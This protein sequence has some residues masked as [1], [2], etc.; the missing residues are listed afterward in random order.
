MAT[1]QRPDVYVEEK[2]Q[3][4]GPIQAAA[5]GK[6]GMQAITEKGP[7]G[8]IVRSSS[9][10]DWVR[11]FGGR[12]TRGDG[13]YEAKM[14]FDEGGVELLTSRIV[15]FSDLDDATSYTGG[16]AYRTH[17]TE[18]VAATSAQKI[19]SAFPLELVAGG[20]FDLD[21]DNAGAATVTF[22][23][24]AGYVDDTTSYPVADQVGLTLLLT[25]DGG[26]QQTVTFGTAT[27]LAQVVED[28]NQ[29]IYGGKAEDNGGQLRITSDTKGTDSTVVINGGTHGLTF[30][31]PVAGTGDVGDIRAVTAAEFKTVVEADTTALC[32]VQG[33]GAVLIS[34]PTTGLTSELDFQAGSPS[35][36]TALGLSVEVIVGT[37]LGATYSTLKL[38]AGYHGYVSPGLKGNSL[39]SKITQNPL[40][41]SAGAGSDL[42]ADAAALA[43]T[44]QMVT[45]SGI[46]AGTVLKIW[47]GTNTEYKEVEKVRVV[48]TAGTPAFYADLTTG[49]TNSFTAA[50]TLIESCEFDLEVYDGIELVET[51]TALSML[52]TADNYVETVLNDDAVGSEYVVATDLDAACGVGAD[53][54]ATDTAAVV[55][56]SGTDETTGLVDADW[57]GSE[58]G[59]TGLYAFDTVREF[60][61]FCS[62]GKNT[63]GVVHSAVAYAESRLYLEY[64]T[65]V[66]VGYTRTQAIG[67]RET[68]LGVNSSYGCLYAGGAKVFDPE[69]SG[70]NPKRSIAALGGLMGIRGRV[71]SMPDPL[72]GPWQT[73]AGEGDYGRFRTAL[74]VATEYTDSDAGP[75][76]VTGINVIRKFGKT[77]PV[78]VFGGRTLYSGVDKRWLYINVRRFFQYVEKSVADSTRWAIFR[79][80]DFR[81]WGSLKDRIDEFLTLLMRRRAFPSNEK[82]KAFFILSGIADGVMTQADVDNGHVISEIGLAPQKPGEF[83]RFRFSQ[84]EAG[85]TIE[86]A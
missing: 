4:E 82:E 35:I 7:V 27:A 21:V 3:L 39:K 66:T 83:I 69:G 13:A 52:D 86:E 74:D 43:T 34:S 73:P 70:S 15:H 16:V 56:T 32:T 65:Y 28:I 68:T 64:I 59:G 1:F 84:F 85:T 11:V 57:V 19:T 47:D 14:F 81:L 46:E 24:A 8:I 9:F 38:Q 33:S 75:M 29:Q 77:S 2:T 63:A 58:V 30:S 26:S 17:I 40:H 61:P 10:T 31:A 20:N 12:E 80:N 5:V 48:V 71:D 41:P 60:M 76:N 42:A 62:V 44:L 22:D 72:G 67:F 23:A 54:P 79:N 50:A 53:T 25:F 78:L 49:L 37:A 51:W 36:L 18:G 45:L 55:F 6:G